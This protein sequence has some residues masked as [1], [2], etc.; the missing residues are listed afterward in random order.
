MSVS[1]TGKICSIC[2]HFKPLH[3]FDNIICKE[4]MDKYNKS[5]DDM[6]KSI[7]PCECRGIIYLIP[8][9]SYTSNMERHFKSQIHIDYI[10]NQ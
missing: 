10:N 2:Y 3:K 5:D 1:F 8:S 7:I 9:L 4:C 6:I